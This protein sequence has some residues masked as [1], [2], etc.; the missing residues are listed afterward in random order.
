MKTVVFTLLVVAVVCST[1]DKIIGGYECPS[2]SQPWQVYLTDGRQACGGSLINERWVVSAAHCKFIH[3]DLYVHLGKHNLDVTEDTEQK[4][5]VEKEIRYPKFNDQPHNND[6][7]LIKLRKPAIFNKYV[8]PIP[9]TTSCTSAG[10]QCLISGWGDT[11]VGPASVLQC[12]NLPVL[13]KTQC[14][15]A[16]DTLI[17]ENM[18]CAGFMEGG[19]DSCT[20]DSGGPVVCNGKLK[21]VVSFGEGCAQPGFPGVYAEVCRYTDWIKDIIAN[22]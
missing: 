19:K 14:K 22:K 12:L 17:T 11:E 1:G 13:S 10:E 21:G 8:K 5:T 6:I 16:Y 4:I 3:D 15:G 20:G 9:L 2:H 18:F 7:M